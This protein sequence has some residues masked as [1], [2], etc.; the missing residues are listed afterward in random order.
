MRRLFFA[1]LLL[2]FTS[3]ALIPARQLNRQT[4][5][6]PGEIDCEPYVP[7]ALRLVQSD[8]GTWQLPQG[9]RLIQKF[10]SRDDAWSGL[11]VFQSYN[12]VCYIGRGN[13]QPNRLDFVMMYLK[14]D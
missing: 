8:R 2:F 12:V 13:T 4:A 6:R 7:S 14:K 10:A 1:V 9:S 11:A 3:T 5:D